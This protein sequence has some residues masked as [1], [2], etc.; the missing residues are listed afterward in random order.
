[1]LWLCVH[2]PQMGIERFQ[3]TSTVAKHQPAVLVKNQKVCLMNTK[4][5]QVGVRLH[6]SLATATSVV[7]DLVNYTHEAEQEQQY[8]KRLVPIAYQW[9]PRVSLAFPY[10]LMLEIAGSLRL[11]GGLDQI[12]RQLSHT[13]R[14]MGHEVHFGVAHI[15]SVA[16]VLAHA[17]VVQQLPPYPVDDVLRQQVEQCLRPLSLQYAEFKPLEIERLFNMGIR[18]FDDLL[19]LPRHELSKRFS[20]QLLNYLARLKGERSEPQQYVQPA[21]KFISE[22]HFIEPVRDK[23]SLYP[24]MQ[25]LLT[26]LV[27]WLRARHLGVV[28]IQWRLSPFKAGGITLPCYFAHPRIEEGTILELSKMALEEAELPPEVMSISLQALRIDSLHQA[29]PIEKDLLG[30]YE[31][32]PVLPSD[33][34]DR[35]GTRLG[36]ESWQLLRSVDDYRPE[37]AWSVTQESDALK[38]SAKQALQ[39]NTTETRPLWLL[40]HP[41]PIKRQKFSIL[42]GPVRIQS[43]WWDK[44]CDRDYF[45]GRHENGSL[46]WLY[47]DG[48]RWLQHGYFS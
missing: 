28:E 36:P 32:K 40:E 41:V 26:E 17:R 25:Q 21:Q 3:R 4:A 18:L 38:K 22:L 46:C 23:P 47:Q 6:S 9:T 19:D 2:L 34:L 29:G 30:N 27:N 15:P 11:F 39:P 45:V 33:L 1:M 5:T 44:Q 7:P 12:M 31:A 10:D 24:S 48:E 35:L 8:L 42:N 20:T 43:G 14:K 16:R 13:F 37:F